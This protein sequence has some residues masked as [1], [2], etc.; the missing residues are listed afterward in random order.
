MQK[1]VRRSRGTHA[2]FHVGSR[3]GLELVFRGQGEAAR[4]VVPR[5]CQQVLLD[6]AH[7]SHVAAD[8]GLGECMLCWLHVYGG[9]TCARAASRFAVSVSAQKTVCSNL[10][11]FYNLSLLRLLGILAIGQSIS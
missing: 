11:D 9:Q 1:L 4:L 2:E 10:L 7:C 5:A 6:E 8:F 3:H